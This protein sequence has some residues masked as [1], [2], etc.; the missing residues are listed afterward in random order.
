MPVVVGISLLLQA[1]ADHVSM[2]E[3]LLFPFGVY[4]T[5]RCA[6]CWIG[7]YEN[8][9]DCWTTFLGWPSKEEIEYAKSQGLTVLPLMVNYDPPR[10]THPPVRIIKHE[11]VPDSGNF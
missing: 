7:L 8:E 2:T 5:D 11:T 1:L 4:N 3:R 9:D 10:T 6:M